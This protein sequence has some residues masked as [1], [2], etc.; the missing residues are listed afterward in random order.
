MDRAADEMYAL[1][2]LDAARARS[3]VPD[4]RSPP[5]HAVA[6]GVHAGLA[7]RAGVLRARDGLPAENK[8]AY[9]EDVHRSRGAGDGAQARRSNDAA[10]AG[11]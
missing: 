10:V 9:V 4:P 7:E 3:A 6:H 5:A 2:C 1:S 11:V 8:S